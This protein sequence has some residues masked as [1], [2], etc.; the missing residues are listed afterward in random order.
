MGGAQLALHAEETMR[1]P[2]VTWRLVVT[3]RYDMYLFIPAECFPINQARTVLILLLLMVV[4]LAGWFL[5]C[6]L[7]AS[8]ASS[9]SSSKPHHQ[10]LF[11]F[12]AFLFKQGAGC[13]FL[14]R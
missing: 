13:H 12:V 11:E 1:V 10:G 7:T 6:R 14:F 5:R 8:K 4:F 2:R 9:S 3:L